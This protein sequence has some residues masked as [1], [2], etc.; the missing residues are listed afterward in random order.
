MAVIK[1]RDSAVSCAKMAEPI[2]KQFGI[3]TWVGLVNH[4]LIGSARPDEYN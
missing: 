1:Y 3:W 2:E 4:A